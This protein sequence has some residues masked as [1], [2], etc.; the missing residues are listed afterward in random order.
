[1]CSLPSAQFGVSGW[2][3]AKSGSDE[4]GQCGHCPLQT[5]RSTKDVKGPFAA[6]AVTSAPS[7]GSISCLQF[8]TTLLPY[9]SLPTCAAMK[10]C[11]PALQPFNSAAS[12]TCHMWS[13]RWK[14][15]FAQTYVHRVLTHGLE[16]YIANMASLD[17]WLASIVNNRL[18]W[19]LNLKNI[20]PD[21]LAK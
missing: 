12:T 21:G 10:N 6:L 16:R 15:V 9:I 5:H 18:R 1:M 2:L 14:C 13:S 19:S 3:V 4:P 7:S 8:T 17:R 20:G 11:R